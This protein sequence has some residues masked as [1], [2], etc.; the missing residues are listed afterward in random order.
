M[1]RLLAVVL[2]VLFGQAL[3]AGGFIVDNCEDGDINTLGGGWWYTYDDNAQGGNSKVEPAPGKFAMAKE[4]NSYA[5][6][7][8]GKAGSKLGWDFIGIGCSLTKESSCPDMKPVDVSKYTTLEFRIKG[9]VAGGRLTVVLPYVEEK[10]GENYATISKTGW[11]DY[12]AAITGKV[13]SEW[14][15]VKLNLRKDFKQ[16][17]WAKN[18]NKAPIESVLKNLKGM[19]FHYTS[20]DGEEIDIMIDDIEF[21]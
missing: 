20:Q 14:T 16:P 13:K 21:K 4:G 9:T 17:A 12:E 15:V 8:K 2:A 7:M 1:K 6:Y 5:A 19:S 18:E 3:F 11:A 10:C